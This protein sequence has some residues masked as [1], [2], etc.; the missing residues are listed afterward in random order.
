MIPQRIV[1]APAPKANA[2]LLPKDQREQ[3]PA[4][5]LQPILT[6]ARSTQQ[7][8]PGTNRADNAVAKRPA[9]VNQRTEGSPNCATE[10]LKNPIPF[11][12]FDTC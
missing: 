6:K 11:T 8:K 5:P 2:P 7:G 12:I 1:A 4:P 3:K 9:V 10:T